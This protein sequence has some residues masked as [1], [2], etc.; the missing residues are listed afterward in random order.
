VRD[1]DG[2]VEGG[3][4]G[5]ERAWRRPKGNKVERRRGKAATV[6]MASKRKIKEHDNNNSGSSVRRKSQK[7]NC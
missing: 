4:V 7:E 6:K 2:D 1:R 5:G 3:M